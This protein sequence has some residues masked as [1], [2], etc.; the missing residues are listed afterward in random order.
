MAILC[1]G[2]AGAPPKGTLDP[3]LLLASEALGRTLVTGDRRSMPDYIRDHYHA[4]HRTAGV[5]LL[6]NGGT[7][8]E[9]LDDL[10]LIWA[11]MTAEELVDFSTYIPI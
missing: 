2:E 6:R 9:Y 8:N 7:W 11:T 4:G 3:D 5:L 10:V 1:I